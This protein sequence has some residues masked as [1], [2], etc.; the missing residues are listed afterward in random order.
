LQDPHGGSTV[1]DL[2]LLVLAA[3]HDAGG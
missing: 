2:A 1:L 3:H